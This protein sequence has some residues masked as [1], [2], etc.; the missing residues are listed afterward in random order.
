M[1]CVVLAAGEGKRM[2]PLTAQ[3]PKVMLP[4]ANRPM[5]EHLV[6]AAR[7]AGITEFI[8]V[9]GYYEREIRNH[10]GDGSALGVKITY[11]TQRHQLGTADA[12]RSTAGLVNGKFL[13]LNGDMVLQSDDIRELCNEK[14]P[15]VGIHQT[16]HPK[17]YGVVTIEGDRITGLEE[18]SEEPKSNLVNAGAYLF[19]PDIFDL[20]SEIKISG[21]GEFEL[22]DA[23]EV[24][25]REGTLTAHPLNYWL[26]VGQPWDLL[27]ANEALI[28]SMHHEQHGIIEDGCTIPET[29]S[30]GKGTI[31]RAGTYIEGSCVIGENCIIGPHAY[32][33]GSTAIGDGCHI[34]HATEIKNSII[35]PGTKIPHFNYIGDS[36]IG[37]NC[38]FGAGTKIANLRHDNATVKV[39]GR[40]TGRRKFGAIIG[41]N[42]LFGINCS[43]NVGSLV[44]SNARIAPHSL[45]EG[46]IEEGSVIR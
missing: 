9:V 29:V 39:C 14:A 12:L 17:D 40:T 27:D 2:R 3:R 37:S 15:C 10:F 5:M 21:R 1:Q 13:L 26:D 22:T 36:V 43:I 18:K 35:M 25:I 30:I 38:N 33:R 42:V 31:I 28:A 16:D 46:C 45:V 34:G 44:G 23:L 41:D 24:Y 20:L 6:L 7:D 4:I 11:V 19:E 8:F 32:I